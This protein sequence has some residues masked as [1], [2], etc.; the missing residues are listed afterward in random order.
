MARQGIYI[1]LSATTRCDRGCSH[2]SFDSNMKDGTDISCQKLGKLLE[3]LEKIKAETVFCITG[4]GEPLLVEHLPEITRMISKSPTTKRFTLVTSGIL[5]NPTEK[6]R[7]RKIIQDAAQDKFR[8]CLSFHGFNKHYLQRFRSTVEF[9]LESNIKIFDIKVTIGRKDLEIHDQLEEIL[10]KFKI[11]PLLVEPRDQRRFK[12]HLFQHKIL[13]WDFHDLLVDCAYMIDCW[14]ISLDNEKN[15]YVYLSTQTLQQKGRAKNLP[16][17]VFPMLRPDCPL[18]Y[19]DKQVRLCVNP[20]GHVLINSTCTHSAMIAG[21]VDDD[22]TKIFRE[23]KLFK[24]EA[25][26]L[27]LSDKRMY[28]R[29]NDLCSLCPK[30]KTEWDARV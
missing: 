29:K 1:N 25:L 13:D 23:R 27:L 8:L 12:M 17:H 22:I 6:E 14:Y 26:R 19:Y 3:N 30:I 11:Y 2:C 5:D 18:F 16:D 21:T 24:K 10:E 4:G 7:L 15:T 20:E 28:E 9:L